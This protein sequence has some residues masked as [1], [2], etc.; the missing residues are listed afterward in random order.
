MSRALRPLPFE[1][2]D[3][4]GELAGLFYSQLPAD[5]IPT[6]ELNAVKVTSSDALPALQRNA[7]N[8]RDFKRLI[9]E[10][11]VVV[12]QVNGHSARALLD[13]GSLADFMSTRFA[14]Q[15]GVKTF[16]LEKPL[17]V[18]LAVQ[19]SRAKI[20]LGCTADLAYQRVRTARYFDVVNLLNYDLIRSAYRQRCRAPS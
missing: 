9:P 15:I 20:N 8:T 10:P 19:G 4:E 16:E 14:H 17:P 7:A 12:V 1:L 3:L 5:C 2:D 11:V 13:T 6:I 18:H